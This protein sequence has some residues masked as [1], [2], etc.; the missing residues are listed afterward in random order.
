MK[1][2]KNEFRDYRQESRSKR[3]DLLATTNVYR[4]YVDGLEKDEEGLIKPDSNISG[5]QFEEEKEKLKEEL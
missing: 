5:T 3:Q 2:E 1:N 4:N